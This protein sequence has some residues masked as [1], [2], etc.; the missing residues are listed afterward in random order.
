[1]SE[2]QHSAVLEKIKEYA[3]NGGIVV[4]GLH[5]PNFSKMDLFDNLFKSFGFDWKHGDYHRTTFQFN[6][7][8]TIP[9][10]VT[11]NS[12]PATY[13]MKALHVKD[14]R[15]EEKIYIPVDGAKTQSHALPAAYVDQA[16]A[17]A[18]AAKV[19]AGYVAY[20]GDVNSEEESNKVILA[21]CGL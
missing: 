6:P 16:Q 13:S 19:G 4:F 14:A 18:V 7:S 12:M 11:S 20:L 8:C 5:M 9:P 2:K 1:L 10:G 15:P 3:M 21:L 17:A